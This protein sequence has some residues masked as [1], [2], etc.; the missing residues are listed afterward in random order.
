[1]TNEVIGTISG[2]TRFIF[3]ATIILLASQAWLLH[4]GRAG[5][6]VVRETVYIGISAILASVFYYALYVRQPGTLEQVS[7]V[8]L[9]LWFPLIYLFISLAYEE[10]GVLVRSGLLYLLAICV[11]LPHAIS[12]MGSTNPFDGFQSLGQFYISSAAFIA[13]LYFFSR[14]KVRLRE[15]QAVAEQMSVL[16]QTDSLTNIP[17]RRALEVLLEQEIERTSR[18]GL[19]LSLITFDLDYFKQ[20][21]DTLG[22]DAGDEVL[23]EVARL[24][25]PCLR[26]SDRFGRWGGEEFTMVTTETSFEAAR[27]LADR[28]RK[29]IESHEFEQGYR[30]SASFGVAAYRP[31]DSAI[32]LFKKTDVALYRAKALGRN[33]VETEGLEAEAVSAEPAEHE[34]AKQPRESNSPSR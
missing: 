27:Q 1:M 5:M 33:R 3:Y 10:R 28:V 22:H 18:Y 15:T 17:N 9:Y 20:L 21:N 25:E 7:L 6:K 31:G 4:S 19:P 11:T 23:V 29:A 32:T 12:T 14:M 24:V 34:S 8:S 13:I 2:F 30:L 26:A 16:A